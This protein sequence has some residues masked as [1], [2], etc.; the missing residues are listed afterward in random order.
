GEARLAAQCFK[1]NQDGNANTGLFSLAAGRVVLT[2]NDDT[3][4]LLIASDQLI[5]DP[6][7]HLN[8][9]VVCGPFQYRS[10]TL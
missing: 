5:N 7:V 3:S 1:V 10:Y 6:V 9:R 2:R 8:V 4:R